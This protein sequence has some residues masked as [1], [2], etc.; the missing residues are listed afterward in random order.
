MR[1][2]RAGLADQQEAGFLLTGK[3]SGERFHCEQDIRQTAIGCGIIAR[4]P[5]I[6]E[7]RVAIERRNACPLLDQTGALAVAATATLGAGR[8]FALDDLPAGTTTMRTNR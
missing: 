3:F 8:S 5:E 2:P 1:L 4:Q 6:V 7:G